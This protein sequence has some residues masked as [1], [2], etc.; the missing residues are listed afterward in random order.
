ME[1]ENYLKNES[2]KEFDVKNNT[3]KN[4]LITEINEELKKGSLKNKDLRKQYRRL[5]HDGTL[6]KTRF[7]RFPKKGWRLV[8][9]NGELENNL[10]SIFPGNFGKG[11]QRILLILRLLLELLGED[12]IERI[13][14]YIIS[15]PIVQSIRYT[16]RT[17][18]PRNCIP[19]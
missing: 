13:P 19:E 2:N 10:R 12:N 17:N 11:S 5:Y 1:G 4:K 6:L 3:G 9:K 15:T 14:H 7:I 16:P 8:E 18:K